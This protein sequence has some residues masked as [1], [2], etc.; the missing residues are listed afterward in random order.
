[1]TD[2]VDRIALTLLI[3]G[4]V[5]W[6]SVGNSKYVSGNG[7]SFNVKCHHSQS[8]G[9]NP[10][11]SIVTLFGYTLLISSSSQIGTIRFLR[12]IPPLL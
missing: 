11:G 5:N 2:M 6:G 4:G 10:D 8:I 7:S 9:T 12:T 3:I 1:M